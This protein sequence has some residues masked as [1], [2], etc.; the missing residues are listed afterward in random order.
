MAVMTEV[1]VENGLTPPPMGPDTRILEETPLDSLQL[2]LT[3]VKLEEASGK[4]PFALGFMPFNT[5]GELASL[6]D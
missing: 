5:I 4:D 1:M 2:A 3:V 6:Y